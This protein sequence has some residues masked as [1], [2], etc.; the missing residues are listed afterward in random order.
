MI[1]N[2]VPTIT[3][4]QFVANSD[5]PFL[6]LKFILF[7]EMFFVHVLTAE[8]QIQLVYGLLVFIV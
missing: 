4:T 3:Y 1:A 7:G 5:I 2:N 8:I 6:L